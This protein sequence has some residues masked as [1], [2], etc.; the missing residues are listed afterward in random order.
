MKSL[1]PLMSLTIFLC[2]CG[3]TCLAA[4]GDSARV[5]PAARPNILLIVV[6]DLGFSDLGFLG[7]EINT[8]N[9]NKLAR[10]GAVLTNFHTAPS[11]SPTRSMLLTGTDNHIAGL[12]TMAEDRPAGYVVHPGDEGYLNFRV[13]ALP[14]L[15]QDAGY[16]TY[17]TG[18]WHLGRTLETSPAARGFE[19]S[20]ALMDG[21]AGHFANRLPIVG[22]EKALYRENYEPVEQLPADFYSTQFYADKMI[23]YIESGRLDDRPFFSYLAFSAPHWPLQ[24][25]EASVR[26]YRGVYDRGYDELVDRRLA[27]AKELGLVPK[28]VERFPRLNGVPAWNDLDSDEKAYE[29]LKMEVYAAM[30][31]DLDIYIGKVIDYLKRVGEYEQTL[32][33]FMSDNGPEGRH[34]DQWEALRN[35]VSSGCCDNRLENI[36]RDNSYIW[37]GPGWGQASNVPTRLFKTNIFQ[38]GVRVPAFAHFPKH[39]V[40]NQHADSVVSVMDVMPTILDIA[41]VEHPVPGRYR[42]R[43]IVA[44]KGTSMLSYLSNTASAV[45]DEDYAIGWEFYGK[46]ALRQGDWKITWTPNSKQVN[47]GLYTTGLTPGQ[48]QLY[49]LTDDP[50]EMHDVSQFHP[51]KTQAL[52]ELWS[53]YQSEVG[54]VISQ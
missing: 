44:M 16:H 17:M 40:R 43:N 10:E 37:L 49:N 11:C 9:L 29:I 46:R 21:G 19:K 54:I 41:G 27:R 26:K 48:W 12:S 51:E 35:W 7:G 28:G 20:F 31:D 24:A 42:G 33:F 30:V 2:S 1:Y 38:G 5:P 45:H 8:P 50:R 3:I 47:H 14:E 25:P 36:G 39:V 18:K 4:E 34:I 6:D 23:E 32:I 13:A 22:P 15:L 53:A 52:I